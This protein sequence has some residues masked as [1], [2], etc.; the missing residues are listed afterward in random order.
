MQ[1]L[2]VCS[3]LVTGYLSHLRTAES[4][5]IPS[6]AEKYLRSAISQQCPAGTIFARDFYSV[7]KNVLGL[8][9]LKPSQI[10]DESVVRFY[11]QENPL[12]KLLVTFCS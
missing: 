2:V 6:G 3:L 4:I 8:Q 10:C 11:L 12:A 7:D 9:C 5:D 1:G